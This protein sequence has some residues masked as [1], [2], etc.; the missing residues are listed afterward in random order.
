MY[1]AGSGE[2]HSLMHFASSG[3]WPGIKKENA[4]SVSPMTVSFDC[5]FSRCLHSGFIIS[6][7]VYILQKG[8]GKAPW[9]SPHRAAS[10]FRKLIL[11]SETWCFSASASKAIKHLI[12]DVPTTAGSQTGT[13]KYSKF[14]LHVYSLSCIIITIQFKAI[15]EEG[16]FHPIFTNQLS[17]SKE[18]HSCLKKKS[19]KK[20]MRS[21][22]RS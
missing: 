17:S 21:H 16:S 4:A 7:F 1:I 13:K 2:I 19:K 15:Y 18:N 12:K 6:Y 11:S 20:S 14:P 10:S 3:I 8:N 5:P 22:H 9:P